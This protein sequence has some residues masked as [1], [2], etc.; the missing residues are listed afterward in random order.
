MIDWSVFY[1][2]GEISLRLRLM[3]AGSNTV[4][5][6]SWTATKVHF[7]FES[8]LLDEVYGRI[9]IWSYEPNWNQSVGLEWN[10]VEQESAKMDRQG[11]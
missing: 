6:E 11:L 10:H 5:I 9:P 8:C 3:D 4:A 1:D 7:L 2:D